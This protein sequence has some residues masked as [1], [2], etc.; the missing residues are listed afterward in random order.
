MAKYFT[1]QKTVPAIPGSELDFRRGV[2]A[3]ISR[4]KDFVVLNSGI[5]INLNAVAFIFPIGSAEEDKRCIVVVFSGGIA[6]RTNENRANDMELGGS[7]AEKL[8][9]ALSA[10]EVD[11]RTTREA[12][13]GPPGDGFSYPRVARGRPN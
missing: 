1:S 6:T 5:I 2:I 7:D 9:A 8:L 3:V 4:M 13:C 10:A 12:L 11:V